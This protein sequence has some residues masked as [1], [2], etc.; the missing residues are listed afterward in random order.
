[1]SYLSNEELNKWMKRRSHR[2]SKSLFLDVYARDNL[3]DRI[4]FYPCTVIINTDSSNLRGKHWV[5][6]YVSAYKVAEY[7]D[8][9]DQPAPHDIALW[10]N[11]F[12]WDWK[13]VTPFCLQNPASTLCG[14]YVLYFVNE[15]PMDTLRTILLPFSKDVYRN[16]LYVK[17]YVKQKFK[18]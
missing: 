4:P 15:R 12:S 1:M 11:K 2:Y 7:F 10:M 16:D 18:D 8:S 14:G 17:T 9:L 5:A 3:P 13:K 6:V